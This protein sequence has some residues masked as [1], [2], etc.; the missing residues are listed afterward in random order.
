MCEDG[1]RATY[2]I[3]LEEG[4]VCDE[5]LSVGCGENRKCY[6]RPVYGLVWPS[7]PKSPFLTVGWAFSGIGEHSYLGV[8][9]ERRL[10]CK[11]QPAVRGGVC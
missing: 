4:L 6:S 9:K 8:H 5:C 3:H 2:V 1:E 10:V 11:R 7:L